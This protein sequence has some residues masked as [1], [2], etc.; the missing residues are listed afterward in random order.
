MNHHTPTPWV[1][2]YG[3]VYARDPETRLALMDRENPDT[4]PTE[5]DANARLIADCVNLVK[6]LTGDLDRR[7]AQDYL[8]LLATPQHTLTGDQLARLSG[9]WDFLGDST[10]QAPTPPIGAWSDR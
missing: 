8:R 7:Q 5:R 2:Q 9:Y 4:T 6:E 3:A 10:D 1:A